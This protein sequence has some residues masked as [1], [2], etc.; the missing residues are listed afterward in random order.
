MLKFKQET[1]AK[2]IWSVYN[3]KEELLGCVGRR[4]VGKFMHFAFEPSPDTYFTNG[5][6]K[7]ISK[8][9]TSLYSKKESSHKNTFA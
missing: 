6:L 5:C 8:F 7:E 1:T 3:D 9:I 4:R 2:Y